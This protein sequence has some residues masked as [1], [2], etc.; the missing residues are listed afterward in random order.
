MYHLKRSLRSGAAA[1]LAGFCLAP[2]GLLD[3]PAPTARRVVP[4]LLPSCSRFALCSLRC[5]PPS[6]PN[7]LCRPRP[8]IESTTK[9]NN[10]KRKTAMITTVV[11]DLH[12]LPR[13]RDH[14]AHLR[15]H[16]AQKAREFLPRVD[17][18]IHGIAHAIRRLP[19]DQR[20]PFLTGLVVPFTI[21]ALVAM[22]SFLRAGRRAMR[23]PT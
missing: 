20:R 8:K 23:I 13:G 5:N 21:A 6:L 22:P 2:A 10:P 17:C 16:I 18:L 12:F 7:K 3:Q 14:L 11:V 9:K 1:R 19:F 15:A 4:I